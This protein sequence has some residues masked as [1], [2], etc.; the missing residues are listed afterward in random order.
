MTP[1]IT[2]WCYKIALNKVAIH[3]MA[4]MKQSLSYIMRCNLISLQ[5]KALHYALPEAEPR[6]MIMISGEGVRVAC[7]DTQ[8]GPLFA[9]KAS[10]RVEVRRKE[11]RKRTLRPSAV[12]IISCLG[13]HWPRRQAFC[14]LAAHTALRTSRMGGCDIIIVGSN[15]M[16]YTGNRI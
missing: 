6:H 3:Y 4:S 10:E 8:A 16:N 5:T 1:K 15:L 11:G 9:D 2:M 14:S 13:P 12:I 7:N